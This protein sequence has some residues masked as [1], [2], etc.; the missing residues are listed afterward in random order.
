MKAVFHFRDSSG[1]VSYTS[2]HV[3]SPDETPVLQLANALQVASSAGLYRASIVTRVDVPHT[4]PERLPPIR[5]MALLGEG[6]DAYH[7]GFPVPDAESVAVIAD[8]LIQNEF[9][10]ASGF[11]LGGLSTLAQQPTTPELFDVPVSAEG[12]VVLVLPKS[13]YFSIVSSFLSQ[14][15]SLTVRDGSASP[16]SGIR[17]KLLYEVLRGIDVNEILTRL[18]RIIS[19]LENVAEDDEELAE[20]VRLL[21]EVIEVL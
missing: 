11:P 20:L 18:D 3:S 7:A 12:S 19:L 1:D 6:T 4:P 9:R 17:R 16:Y 8:Y 2:I 21:T 15:V 5:R 13:V 14:Y 10:T